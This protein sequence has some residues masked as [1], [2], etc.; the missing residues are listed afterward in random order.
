MEPIGTA[1][2]PLGVVLGHLGAS[3]AV[4]GHSCASL[5]IPWGVLGRSW[6]FSGRSGGAL[7][8]AL[9]RYSVSSPVLG[10]LLR[11]LGSP[12]GRFREERDRYSRPCICFGEPKRTQEDPREPKRTPSVLGFKK[13]RF[14]L[15]ATSGL[16]VLMAPGLRESG[17]VRGT[18]RFLA[19]VNNNKMRERQQTMLR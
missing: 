17:S 12:L 11:F 14:P 7:L 6:G 9:G 3:G 8:V 19:E 10:C 1:L 18:N 5:G 4:W 16:M 15:T 13:R 2:Q